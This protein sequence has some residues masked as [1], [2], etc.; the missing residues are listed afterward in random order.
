MH[1][2]LHEGNNPNNVGHV[3]LSNEY[4]A[5]HFISFLLEVSCFWNIE[6]SKDKLEIACKYFSMLIFA[7]NV[8]NCLGEFA[9]SL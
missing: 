3:K 5:I 8:F 2:E 6:Y 9:D 7:W 4:M 1:T